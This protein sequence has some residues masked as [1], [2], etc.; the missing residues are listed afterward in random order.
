MYSTLS[1]SDLLVQISVNTDK[2]AFGELYK[3]Y[4]CKL[5]SFARYYLPIPAEAED[6]V[7]DVFVNLLKKHGQLK[8]IDNFDGYIFFAVKNHCLNRIKKNK[9]KEQFSDITTEIDIKTDKCTQPLEQL[10]NK[11]LSYF[12]SSLVE[13]LPSKRKLVFKMIKDDGLKIAEVAKLLVITEKTVKKHL[14]LAVKDLRKGI[15]EYLEVKGNNT[16]TNQLQRNKKG[17]VI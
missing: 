16:K 12:Y 13:E 4:H 10:L 7:S 9:R 8:D 14:E 6:V 3:R 1:N 15:S 2:K 11:E 5:V 17:V